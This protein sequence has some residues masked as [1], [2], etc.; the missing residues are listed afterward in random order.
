MGSVFWPMVWNF[1]GFVTLVGWPYMSY[2]S[3]TANRNLFRYYTWVYRNTKPVKGTLELS[4]YE[5]DSSLYFS[6]Q[7]SLRRSARI[8]V[9]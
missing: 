1:C 3:F 8:N 7:K 9:L 6:A 5:S 4:S 2:S